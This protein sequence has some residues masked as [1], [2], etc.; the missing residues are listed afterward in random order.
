MNS[1]KRE[2]KPK[3]LPKL[4]VAIHGAA[5][6][7]VVL[8]TKRVDETTFQGIVLHVCGK[9]H[10]GIGCIENFADSFFTEYQGELILSN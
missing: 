7:S 10:W 2:A 1:Q 8:A 6:G 9:A 3:D 5:K 4:M